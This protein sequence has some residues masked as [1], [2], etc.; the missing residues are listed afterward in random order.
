MP[1]GYFD[2]GTVHI[3]LGE[4]AFAT[5]SAGRQV[6]RLTGAGARLYAHGGG[7]LS[8]AVTG[9]R[10]R[11]NLGD[12]ERYVYETFRALAGAGPGVLGVADGEGRRAT[13]GESVCVGAEGR[14]RADRFADMQ[15]EF[16]CP[17]KSAEP[18]WGA[19]PP[20]PA[21]YAGTSTARDYAA[22][23]VALGSGV[24]MELRMARLDPTRHLPR[25]RGMR[26]PDLP[27]SA[28]FR[29]R[30]EGVAASE[31]ANRAAELEQLARAIG[32]GPVDLTGNG[33][34]YAG[35]LLLALEPKHA[36]RGHAAFVAEFALEI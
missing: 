14:V 19:V 21:V 6:L 25:A 34:T 26:C 31:T 30:V 20:A 17:E 2:D 13:F 7:L 33:N 8:V 22:G 24:G 9:Q 32:S 16:A 29:L 15:F 35:A 3:E 11:D 36:D 10:L 1:G 28:E 18:A 4:H 12:A 5:P 23:G 27:A